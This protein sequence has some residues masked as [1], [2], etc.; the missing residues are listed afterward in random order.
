VVRFSLFLTLS[1]SSLSSFLTHFLIIFQLLFSYILLILSSSF[2][3]AHSDSEEDDIP[4]GSDGGSDEVDGL[5]DDGLEKSQTNP[6][7]DTF[8]SDDQVDTAT[9]SSQVRELNSSLLEFTENIS[10]SA[11]TFCWH[12]SHS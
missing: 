4:Q 9:D 1:L 2:K 6:S 7:D 12:D 11:T 3:M 5:D 10:T 8:D